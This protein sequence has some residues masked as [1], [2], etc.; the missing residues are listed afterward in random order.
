MITKPFVGVLLILCAAA[1]SASAA[2]TKCVTVEQGWV[3]L[4]PNPKMAMT[5]GYAVIRNGCANEVAI[6]G[7]RSATFG[8]VSLHETTIVDGVSRMREVRRLPLAPGARAVLKPGG[9]HLMLMDGYRTL[10][11]G[12]PV[13]LQLQLEDGTEVSTALIARKAAP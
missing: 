12:Q 11:E 2:E 5:A 3:R 8:D 9:L 10:E 4:L 1:A 7:A 13:W 6:T